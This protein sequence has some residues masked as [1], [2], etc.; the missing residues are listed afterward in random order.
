MEKCIHLVT[1][2]LKTKD[3]LLI[4]LVTKVL[5]YSPKKRLT[6]AEAL[7]HEYFDELRDETNYQELLFRAKGLPDLFDFTQGNSAMT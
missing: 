1:K 5:T 6:A 3:P 2:L 7:Y 4:D